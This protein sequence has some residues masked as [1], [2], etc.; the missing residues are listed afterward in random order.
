MQKQK[1]NHKMEN[2]MKKTYIVPTS[3]LV[4]IHT[5]HLLTGSNPELTGTYQG[6]KVL[7]RR[8]RSYD[9]DEEEQSRLGL[10]HTYQSCK[11]EALKKRANRLAVRPFLRIF[12]A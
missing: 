6:G 10:H 3:K 8:D 7:S 4:K 9:W 2:E 5:T 12:A 1:Y 11:G